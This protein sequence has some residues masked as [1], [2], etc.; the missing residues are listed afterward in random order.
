MEK[1][2]TE[3]E[4]I[5]EE[6][7]WIKPRQSAYYMVRRQLG[8]H[9]TSNVTFLVSIHDSIPARVTSKQPLSLAAQTRLSKYIVSKL[10]DERDLATFGKLVARLGLLLYHAE[11]F[12]EKKETAP[13]R[14]RRGSVAPRSRQSVR[15]AMTPLP[16]MFSVPVI[17]SSRHVSSSCTRDVS[18]PTSSW[19][20]KSPV[21][22][23]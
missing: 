12:D 4:S 23:T 11:V 6:A 8:G 20:A 7:I 10:V 22:A 9:Y 14:R 2:K 13:P 19:L 21:C 15:D 1:T 5:K 17:D 18:S 16:V 3:K